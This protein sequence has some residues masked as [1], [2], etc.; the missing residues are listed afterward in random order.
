MRIEEIIELT[1]ARKTGPD[2]WVGHCPVHDDAN[3]SMTIERGEKQAV[4]LRCWS[5]DA[6]FPELIRALIARAAGVQR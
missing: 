6:R 3:P 1:H 2:K 4:L 5:C